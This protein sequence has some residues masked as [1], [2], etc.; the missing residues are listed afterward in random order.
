MRGIVFLL[1]FVS[2][3]WAEINVNPPEY[4]F[5][6]V[7]LGKTSEPATFTLTNEYKEKIVI[8][9]VNIAGIYYL[10]FIIVKD[11]CS[12]RIMDPGTSC[13]IQVS[14][15]P[16]PPRKK[17][18]E[19]AKGETVE[20]RRESIIVIPYGIFPSIEAAERKKIKIY[21]TLRAKLKKGK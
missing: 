6:V 7:E 13:E 2:L 4:D 3:L 19:E 8:G 15:H 10:D 17:E 9:T 16:L 11:E 5:G 21:G 14:F 18:I 1:C 20:L 12:Y